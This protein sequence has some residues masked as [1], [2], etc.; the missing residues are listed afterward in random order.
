MT[1]III[2]CFGLEDYKFED[3]ED[4]EEMATILEQHEANYNN[5]DITTGMKCYSWGEIFEALQKKKVEE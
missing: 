3:D 4:L 1:N 5:A 2:E